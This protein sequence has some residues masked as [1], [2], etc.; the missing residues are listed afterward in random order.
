M[1]KPFQISTLDDQLLTID[2]YA[3]EGITATTTVIDDETGDSIC[4]DSEICRIDMMSGLSYLSRLS[5]S[6]A[7]TIQ[8]YIFKRKIKEAIKLTFL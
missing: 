1:K 7:L 5:V 8:K 3:V 6:D 4:P 2:L